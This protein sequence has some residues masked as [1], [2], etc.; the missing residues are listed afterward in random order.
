MG[1]IFDHPC[2]IR[3]HEGMLWVDKYDKLW[4]FWCQAYAWYDGR[5]GVWGACVTGETED[6]EPIWSTPKRY[7]DGTMANPPITLKNGNVLFP[8]SIWKRY[9]TEYNFLPELEQSSVYISDDD[10]QSV[11]YVGGVDVKDSTF[12]ENSVVELQD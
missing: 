9:R 4:F 12:N 3:M 6:G 2:S 7:C 1:R 8:V 11:K 10:L 5:S